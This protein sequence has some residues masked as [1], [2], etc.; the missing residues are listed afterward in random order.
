M[1][2]SEALKFAAGELSKSE[3][4]RMKVAEFERLVV[5]GQEARETIYWG[6]YSFDSSQEHAEDQYLEG[7]VSILA[8]PPHIVYKG[9][10]ARTGL[11]IIGA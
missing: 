8:E 2:E 5:S 11:V 10:R 9:G 6:M 1:T 4:P 3:L 7:L